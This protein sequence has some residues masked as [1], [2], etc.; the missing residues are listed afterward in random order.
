MRRG[1]TPGAIR[2]TEE[3]LAQ[4]L[5]ASYRTFL[6]VTSGWTQIWMD[7]EDGTILPVEGIGLCRD[8]VPL[9]YSVLKAYPLPSI[10]DKEYY[11]YSAEGAPHCRFS[12]SLTP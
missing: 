4:W 6:E 7:S 5:P 10:S 2:R 1:A 12:R 3:R 11:V 8:V 9:V